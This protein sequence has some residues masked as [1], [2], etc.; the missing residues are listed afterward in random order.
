MSARR[1]CGQALGV[2][3]HARQIASQSQRLKARALRH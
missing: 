3:Q 2:K 1:A